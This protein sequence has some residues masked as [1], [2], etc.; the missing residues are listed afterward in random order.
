M[1]HNL[2]PIAEF[3]QYENKKPVLN[4]E[5]LPTLATSRVFRTVEDLKDLIQRNS[6]QHVIELFAKDASE[7]EQWQ[8]ARQYIEYLKQLTIIKSHN[9]DLPVIDVDENGNDVLAE[10]MPLPDPPK[11]PVLKSVDE[12]LEPFEREIFKK[13]RADNVANIKVTVDDMEFDGDELSTERMNQRI[14]IMSDTDT[15]LWTL[16][17]NELKEVT[18]Q[19]LFE[20]FKLAVNEQSKLWN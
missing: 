20:A 17:N 1:Q 16:A 11:K 18:K 2:K 14:Q 12:F 19:Q 15:Y 9:L 6:P 3:I 4:S 7:A 8:F 10:P 5:G 13:L